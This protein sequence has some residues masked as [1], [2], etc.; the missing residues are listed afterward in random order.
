[1]HHLAAWA[2]FA[3]AIAFFPALAY[4]TFGIGALIIGL[5]ATH[6]LASLMIMGVLCGVG[7]LV[8]FYAG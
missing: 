2:M 8:S 7:V 6:L 1:M 3:I 5:E 4:V